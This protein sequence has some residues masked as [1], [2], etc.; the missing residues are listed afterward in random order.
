MYTF[1][2]R[3]IDKR[4]PTR[5]DPQWEIT[6]YGQDNL[7][8]QRMSELFKRSPLT[9]SAI[10]ILTEFVAGEGWT[11]NHDKMINRFGQTW[12]DLLRVASK[13]FNTFTG[14]ALHINYD[15]I[16]K[17]IE[18]QNVPFKYI[19]LGQKNRQGITT[20]CKLSSNWEQ[21]AE[22]YEIGRAHV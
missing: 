6:T 21:D 13:E 12:N 17:I 14:F 7:Y 8:P 1:V 3:L 22:K 4:L 10:E 2:S 15:G 5:I 19:R 9:K 16:G 18:V 20:N 11:S